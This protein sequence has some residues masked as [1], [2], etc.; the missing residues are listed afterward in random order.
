MLARASEYTALERP[1]KIVTGGNNE[2]EAVASVT[3]RGTITDRDEKEHCVALSCFVVPG[4]GRH[5]FSVKVATKQGI[6]A[7]FDQHLPRLETTSFV[8]PLEQ[9]THDQDLY[10]FRMKLSDYAEQRPGVAVH[11]SASAN[12]WHR[13]L[14]HVGSKSLDIL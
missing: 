2:V 6:I 13:R 5:L 10:T 9:S 14:D 1:F 12:I 11:V 3:I 4:L 8:L 7:I